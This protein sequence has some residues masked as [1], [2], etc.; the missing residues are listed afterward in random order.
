MTAG[1]GKRQRTQVGGLLQVQ[2]LVKATGF[3][4]LRSKQALGTVSRQ[5]ISTDYDYTTDYDWIGQNILANVFFAIKP[6]A[7]SAIVFLRHLLTLQRAILNS[8]KTK[9]EFVRA[10]LT[11]HQCFYDHVQ[12][13]QHIGESC[14]RLVISL[15]HKS[16]HHDSHTPL[17]KE[18]FLLWVKFLKPYC[19][20]PDTQLETLEI[21]AYH[22][23][24]YC[25]KLDIDSTPGFWLRI[26]ELIKR[27]PEPVCT[28]MVL[29]GSTK[30]VHYHTLGPVESLLAEKIFHKGGLGMVCEFIGNATSDRCAV[31]LYEWLIYDDRWENLI[32]RYRQWFFGKLTEWMKTHES[33]KL[34]RLMLK[35]FANESVLAVKIDDWLEQDE[36]WMRTV[37]AEMLDP[38]CIALLEHG[39]DDIWIYEWVKILTTLMGFCPHLVRELFGRLID[40]F[41]K[42]LQQNSGK[43]FNMEYVRTILSRVEKYDDIKARF[44]AKL[45]RA[46]FGHLLIKN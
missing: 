1:D 30:R 15:L 11:Y 29:P 35:S 9:L 28:L 43:P 32:S 4:D 41:L 20:Q 14:N 2:L 23:R 13:H 17:S 5:T 10:S 34:R 31:Q 27:F 18:V 7:G 22:S 44:A 37:F 3:L 46:H 24:T 26:L 6:I 19:F 12:Q 16:I 42:K 45:V 8:E 39:C 21:L 36:V 33:V 40:V 25:T 38:S